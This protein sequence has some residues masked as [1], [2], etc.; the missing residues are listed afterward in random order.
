MEWAVESLGLT[1]SFKHH[2]AV[3]GIDL[4]VPT[5]SIYGFLGSNG[6]GKSTTIRMILGLRRPSS[7]SISLFGEELRHDRRPLIGAMADSPGGAFYDHLSAADNLRVTAGAL[8]LECDVP[9]LLDRVGLAGKERQKVGGFSTGM[10]QRLGIARALIGD[11]ALIILDEPLN[12]LDPEG[13]RAMRTLLVELAEGRTMIIC[14]HL[15]SEIEK[16]ATHIGLLSRGRLIHQG[17]LEDLRS[18]PPTVAVSSADERLASQLHRLGLDARCDGGAH[19]VTLGDGW[20]PARLNRL[21]VESGVEI[22]A[23]IPRKFCL[24]EF[25]HDRVSAY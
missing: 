2:V 18:G 5:G 25:Y 17:P 10:R 11:P 16:V 12:G 22:D 8:G 1:K 19:Q 13:I 9:A 23:L 6:A 7:G 24:E 20:R 14:S 4:S 15:L 21:L 3:D